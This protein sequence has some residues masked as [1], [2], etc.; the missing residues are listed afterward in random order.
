MAVLKGM[1]ADIN[2]KMSNG[3]TPLQWAV[4]NNHPEIVELL[5]QCAADQPSNNRLTYCFDE[6]RAALSGSEKKEERPK[7]IELSIRKK[8]GD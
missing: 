2:K 6:I 5:T 3:E 7:M 8:F 1:G 4:K